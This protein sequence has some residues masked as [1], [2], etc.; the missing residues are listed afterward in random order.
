MWAVALGGEINPFH[1]KPVKFPFLRDKGKENKPTYRIKTTGFQF[2]I[3]QKMLR[4]C[5]KIF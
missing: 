1:S 2:H 4:Q 3:Q 5:N